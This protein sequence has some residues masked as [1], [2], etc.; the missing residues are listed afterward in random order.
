MFPDA[1]VI[2]T[3][4]DPKSWWKSMQTMQGMTSNWYLPLVVMWVPKIGTYGIWREKFKYMAMWRYGEEMFTEDTLEKHEDL[5]AREHPRRQAALVR[6]QGRLG[7]ALQDPRRAPCP[8]CPSRTTTASPTPRRRTRTSSGPASSRGCSSSASAT[9]CTG[10]LCEDIRN[11]VF[12][13]F[14]FGRIIEGI[15]AVVRVGEGRKS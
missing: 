1:T 6:R 13:L 14:F 8:T 3:T 15:L 9:V 12:G 5:P 11:P 7:A 4:R 2:A 10:C